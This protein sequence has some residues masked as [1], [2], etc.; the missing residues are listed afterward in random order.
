MWSGE[1]LVQ[2]KRANIGHWIVPGRLLL[3]RT[4]VGALPRVR[5]P[6]VKMGDQVSKFFARGFRQGASRA[7]TWH[8]PGHR[9]RTTRLRVA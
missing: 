4:K 6:G 9:F 2:I 1:G 7:M 5:T 8:V 3:S